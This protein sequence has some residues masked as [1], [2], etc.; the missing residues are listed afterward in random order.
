MFSLSKQPDIPPNPSIPSSLNSSLATVFSI[1][2]T[3]VNNRP[4]TTG[5]NDAQPLFAND[6]SAGDPASMG[7]AVLLANWTNAGGA[8]FLGA[9]EQELN[10]LFNV[11]PK[12]PQGAI[13]HRTDQVQLW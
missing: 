2:R 8:D 9:A 11:A 13:S 5:F 10:Y 12:T 4:N 3:V 7:V 1:A 6:T